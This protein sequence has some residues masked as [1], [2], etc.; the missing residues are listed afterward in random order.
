M[1]QENLTHDHYIE[2]GTAAFLLCRADVLRELGGFD[3][4]FFMYGEDLDL[5]R[6][7]YDMKKR[8]LWTPNYTVTHL[9]YQSGLKSNNT[10]IQKRIRW[11]FYDA[12]L[13]FYRKHYARVYCPCITMLTQSILHILR[14]R[15]RFS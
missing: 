11:H 2:A 8:I 5:C 12:M 1:M 15:Y 10:N 3:E 4:Q 9:K 7:I 13:R 6:R 14:W